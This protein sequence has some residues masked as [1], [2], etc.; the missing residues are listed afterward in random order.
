MRGF[1]FTTRDSDASESFMLCILMNE[2]RLGAS[3]TC[4][5]V[6]IL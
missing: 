4:F 1:A 3:A 2:L 5:Y 6:L